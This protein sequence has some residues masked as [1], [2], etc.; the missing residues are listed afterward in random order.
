MKYCSVI[1]QA[2]LIF[3]ILSGTVAYA[4]MIKGKSN[5]RIEPNGKLIALLNDGVEVDLI[6]NNKDEDWYNIGLRTCESRMDATNEMNIPK[7]EILQNYNGVE[8]G[9]LKIELKSRSGLRRKKNGQRCFAIVGVTHKQNIRRDSIV[10]Y[11]LEKLLKDSNSSLNEKSMA[12]FIEKHG[13]AEWM[14]NEEISSYLKYESVFLD[15]SPQER[16][17]LVFYHSEL[18]ALLHKNHVGFTGKNSRAYFIDHMILFVKDI[19]EPEKKKIEK[20]FYNIISIAD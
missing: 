2:C 13:F 10:E 7:G 9:L 12:D 5:V 14:G 15:E 18:V 3:V 20:F 19:S 8:V 16:L 11:E 1:I 6:G 17:V 4:E